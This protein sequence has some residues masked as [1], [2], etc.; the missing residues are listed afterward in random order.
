MNKFIIILAIYHLAVFI[1]RA[2]VNLTACLDILT[3]FCN[4]L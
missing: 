4:G 1:Q 3:K 2:C